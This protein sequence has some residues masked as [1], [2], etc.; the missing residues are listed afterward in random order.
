LNPAETTQSD[1]SLSQG[2]GAH[3]AAL[4]EPE[5]VRL[6]PGRSALALEMIEGTPPLEAAYEGQQVIFEGLIHNR[7]ELL[8][9][10][11]APDHAD[12]AALI[13]H[14]YRVFGQDLLERVKGCFVVLI[15]DDVRGELICARD[16]LG[17]YPLFYAWR[18]ESLL[19][20][21]DVQALVR[22]PCVSAALNRVVLAEQLCSRVSKMEETHYEA[23]RRVPQGHLMVWRG[24]KELHTGRYWDPVLAPDSDRWLREDE[25]EQFD[26]VGSTPSASPR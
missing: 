3:W 11:K 17:T 26:A 8:R 2:L 16:P 21:T 22:Q 1:A 19:L 24:G 15:W 7:F 20:S 25:L 23:V 18:E 4:F 5:R 13:L 9:E 14:A 6:H 10:A 12:D